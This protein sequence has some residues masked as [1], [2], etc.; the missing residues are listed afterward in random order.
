[1]LHMLYFVE[2]KL[3]I[4]ILLFNVQNGVDFHV[5]VMVMHIIQVYQVFIKNIVQMLL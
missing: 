1:M 2:Q 3:I 4:L 5:E